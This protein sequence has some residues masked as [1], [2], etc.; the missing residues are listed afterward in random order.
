MIKVGDAFEM[1]D[2]LPDQSV[3]C[4]VTGPPAFGMRYYDYETHVQGEWLKRCLGLEDDEFEYAEAIRGIMVKIKRV[5]RDDGVVWMMLGDE[6]HKKEKIPEA[7]KPSGTLCGAPWVTALAVR[8][9]GWL[10]RPRNHLASCDESLGQPRRHAAEGCAHSH[11]HVHK[12]RGRDELPLQ[13]A[14]G[15][16]FEQH[17]GRPV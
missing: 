4:V 5:L 10:I 3:H 16:G 12:V 13:P 1:L 17:H 11:L 7:T 15:A 14:G 8:N 9:G 6:I 2:E